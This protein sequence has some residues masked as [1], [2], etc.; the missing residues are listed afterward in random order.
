MQRGQRKLKVV[1]APNK[2]L[3]LAFHGVREK[4]SCWSDDFS[5][6]F[7]DF[8]KIFDFAAS[9]VNTKGFTKENLSKISKFLDWGAK[10]KISEKTRNFKE[11]SKDQHWGF[12]LTPW[13]AR[14]NRLF[15]ANA[16]FNFRWPRPF[17]L[18]EA[19]GRLHIVKH[20]L[21]LVFHFFDVYFAWRDLQILTPDYR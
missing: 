13:K 2:R 7:R 17:P 15:G 4:K 3:I 5:S 18:H 8:S 21:Q 16:T 20:L 10:S 12:S 1:L 6:K 14:I 19:T 11:K 9:P